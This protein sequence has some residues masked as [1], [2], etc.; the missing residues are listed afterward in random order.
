MSTC[1]NP[2]IGALLPAYEM[3]ILS[4]E[5]LVAF[6]E[7]LYECA[8]CFE[9][10][11]EFE[12]VAGHILNSDKVKAGISTIPEPTP[13][14]PA[15]QRK[16]RLAYIPVFA[17]VL[18]I[19]ILG[20]WNIKIETS[21]D[22]IATANRV[23]IGCFEDLT[24]R[25]DGKQLTEIAAH[26]LANDLSESEFLQVVP[27]SRVRG[28]LQMSEN[29]NICALPDERLWD[30]AEQANARWIISGAVIEQDGHLGLTSTIIDITTGSSVFSQQVLG[31]DTDNVFSL[32]NRL[33]I[34]I[35]HDMSMPDAKPSDSDILRDDVTTRSALA[36]KYYLDGIQFVEQMYSD[37]AVRA[38]ENA[39]L[40]DST[41]AMAYYYLSQLKDA[42]LINKAFEY[43]GDVTTR[44]RMLIEGLR[45]YYMYNFD[46]AV[47][48]LEKT[49]DRHPDEKSA[50]LLLASIKLSMGN[51]QAAE[52]RYLQSLEIDP[53]YKPA[54][55]HLAMLY[56]QIGEFEKA[57]LTINRYIDVAPNEA[58]PYAA[59]G[60]IYADFGE[61]DKSIEAFETALA[62]KKDFPESLKMLGVLYSFK[63][64][65]AK[66]D[67]A[68][69]RVIETSDFNRRVWVRLYQ[70][71]MLSRQGRLDSSLVIIEKLIHM[72]EIEKASTHFMIEARLS[73]A[74]ILQAQRK[75]G[76]ALEEIQ[77]AIDRLRTDSP[78][79]PPAYLRY[80]IQFLTDDHRI[81]EADSILEYIRG[82]MQQ[83]PS[84]TYVYHYGLGC[85]ELALDNASGAIEHFQ[86]A[87]D[88][89]PH[90]SMYG[91]FE[92]KLMLG[93][94]YLQ[95]GNIEQA[96]D[97]FNDLRSSYTYFRAYWSLWDVSSHYY[98]GQAYEKSG[99][100]KRAAIEY[101]TLLQFWKDGDTNIVERQEAEKRLAVLQHQS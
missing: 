35:R 83:I 94:A 47:A 7:H 97:A 54:L 27:A 61:I 100:Y 31:D 38:F 30:A 22:A 34:Q 77:F 28:L 48:V 67:S 75:Y 6:E 99:W 65:F 72:G 85:R 79:M 9:Q 56:G 63:R 95:S 29:D 44:E 76:E 58:G 73:R 70:A 96:V 93:R 82:Y 57:I 50:Y 2:K 5:D 101:E 25:Q 81:A 88:Y 90:E 20:P 43:S 71:T 80:K 92:T 89:R 46:S 59:K 3:G 41:M 42:R 21:Q 91:H 12:P 78:N 11:Q 86:R 74:L 16:W 55:N 33:T 36:Y 17:V 98:L 32:A 10:V 13:A 68:F 64:E 69:E 15:K 24:G 40:H 84:L 37:E 60:K 18:L 49:I 66:S 8:H 51:T 4:G 1:S 45:Y 26:L 39:L 52:M 14:Y 19:V 23:I 53:Y 87:L 62:K